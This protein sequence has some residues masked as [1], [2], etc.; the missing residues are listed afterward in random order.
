MITDK[1]YN[2]IRYIPPAVKEIVRDKLL[3]SPYIKN[4]ESN[5]EK[6]ENVLKFMMQDQ[7][8]FEEHRYDFKNH[9]RALD[10]LR[11]ENIEEVMPEWYNVLRQHD[12]I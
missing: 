9:Q 8:D 2:D 5:L 6:V 10:T 1:P 12:F 4:N 7:P 11:N 3:N